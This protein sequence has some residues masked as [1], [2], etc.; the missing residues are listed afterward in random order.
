MSDFEEW[1][2][3]L[4]WMADRDYKLEIKD[5]KKSH[6][7]EFYDAGYSIPYALEYEDE[8]SNILDK[9]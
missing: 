1:F 2:A 6:W 8:W 3:R 4:K 5:N 7:R 9:D